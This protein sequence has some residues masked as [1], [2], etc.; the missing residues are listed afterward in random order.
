MGSGTGQGCDDAH[1]NVAE[2]IPKYGPR[3]DEAQLL[4]EQAPYDTHD[5]LL[6]RI[7]P[8]RGARERERERDNSGG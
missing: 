5:I 8:C 7:E 6:D 4:F 2:V 3:R 1:A